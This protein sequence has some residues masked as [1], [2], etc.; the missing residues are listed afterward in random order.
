MKM[1]F[2]S[3]AKKLFGIRYER[4][5][6]T[7]FAEL[8]VFLG[9]SNAGFKIIIAP[10]VI[11]FTVTVFTSGVMWQSL[12]SD[13]N[14]ACLMNMM[15]LP[16]EQSQFIF[17]YTAA[18]GVY[19]LLTKTALLAAVLL[20]V[21]V[22]SYVEAAACILCAVHAV[23]ITAVVFSLKKY[24]YLCGIFAAAVTAMIIFL[25]D[26]LL[27]A[28]VMTGSILF[29]VLL[30]R[31]ADGYMFYLRG[32]MKCKSVKSRHCCL[33]WNYFW[34]YMKAHRNYL[35][36]TAVMWCIA[37]LLPMIFGQTESRFAFSV[38]FAI[39]SM[40]TPVCILL[41]AD[42]ALA[43]AVRYLP[44]GVKSFLTPYCL[45]VFLCNLTADIFFLCSMQVQSGSVTGA[46]IAAAVLTSFLSA[47]FC[48]LLEWV[49]PICGW[50]IESDLWHHP[51][52]YIV[53][54][55]WLLLAGVIVWYL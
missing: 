7:L 51:R 52:K 3:F 50:K 25:C 26:S 36:N 4:L 10:S 8:I 6:R 14:A 15:M 21:S 47:L 35:A 32:Q 42:P 43:Q 45:F 34:R 48:V 1:I 46:V 24:R 12:C 39:L 44:G 53:P 23:L 16:F 41:S 29:S 18:V 9:L 22:R 11:C 5:I 19:T 20:A 37:V 2:N 55:I 38:G 17:S 28:A 54:A 27:T 13:D 40:N 33:V 31:K 49:C 30:L